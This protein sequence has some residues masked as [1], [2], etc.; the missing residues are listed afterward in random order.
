MTFEQGCE[1]VGASHLD[2]FGKGAFKAEGT[3][4]I[5]TQRQ[6]QAWVFEKK[7]ELGLG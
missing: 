7:S 4:R 3:A 2:T 6:E 1:G 5:K